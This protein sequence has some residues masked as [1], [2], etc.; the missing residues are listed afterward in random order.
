MVSCHIH[1]PFLVLPLKGVRALAPISPEGKMGC[2]GINAAPR[3]LQLSSAQLSSA[4]LGSDPIGLCVPH[5]SS[6]R[7]E[8]LR[9]DLSTAK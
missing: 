9:M 4:Q 2:V 3:T 1:A 5:R 8:L 6:A 7:V